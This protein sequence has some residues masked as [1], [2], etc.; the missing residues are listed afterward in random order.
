[1]IVF[2][3][4]KYYGKVD[5]VRGLF[6]VATR[7]FHIQLLP[8]IPLGSYLIL[9]DGTK[10]DARFRVFSVGLSVRSMVAGLTRGFLWPLTLIFAVLAVVTGTRWAQGDNA[11]ADR[12]LNELGAALS[13][14]VLL[15][16]SY[17]FTR[18]TR[19][20]AVAWAAR[21]GFP[22]DIVERCFDAGGESPGDELVHPLQDRAD[23][24]R[25]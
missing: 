18:A 5:H 8:L 19:K 7:L 25:R 17:R 3:G 15:W 20:R 2:F 6:Y 1:M 11:L 13:F 4:S 14:G 16:A 12:A 21:A 22:T 9:D 23:E 24:P 10:D